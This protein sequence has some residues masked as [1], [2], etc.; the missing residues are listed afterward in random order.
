MATIRPR[1]KTDGSISHTAQTMSLET[2]WT[3]CGQA[4]TRKSRT[5]LIRALARSER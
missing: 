1:K 2:R 3:Y 5:A 4:S